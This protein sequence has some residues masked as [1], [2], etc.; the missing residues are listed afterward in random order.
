MSAPHPEDEK[1][2]V[3]PFRRREKAACDQS[4]TKPVGRRPVG[5]RPVGYQKAGRGGPAQP[6]EGL[7]KYSADGAPTTIASA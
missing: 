3:L 6:V 1:G 5:C 2:R 7:E 4:G